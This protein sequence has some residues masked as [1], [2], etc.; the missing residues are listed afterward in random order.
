MKNQEKLTW[1]GCRTLLLML[2]VILSQNINAQT[3][4]E[5]FTQGSTPT[6]DQ[7]TT[8]GAFTNSLTGTYNTLTVSSTEG[9]TNIICTDAT[10]VNQIASAMSSITSTV[11]TC[12]GFDWSVGATSC[13]TGLS[14]LP[15]GDA[16]ELTVNPTGSGVFNCSCQTWAFNIRPAIGNANWGGAGGVV[17]TCNAP[18]QTMTVSFDSGPVV[19]PAVPT[20]GE[21]GLIIL[22]LLVLSFGTVYMMRHQVAIAGMMDVSVSPNSSIP[23]ERVSYGKMLGIVMLGL[24]T[25]FSIAVLL[26]GYEMTSADVPGSLIAGPIAAYLLH[27]IIGIKKR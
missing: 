16:V 9:G 10:A 14:C 13:Q 21:W 26:F 8:W 22:A 7:C 3:Y 23:F 18:S 20:M 27:L 2:F 12:N 17:S 6:N 25:V 4:S 5:T 24:V 1:V 19:T 11:V 15:S